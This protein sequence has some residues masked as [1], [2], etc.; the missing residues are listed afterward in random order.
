[1][2]SKR[3]DVVN[4]QRFTEVGFMQS[5]ALAYAAV[6]LVCL[7]ALGFPFWAVIVF[8][9]AAPGIAILTDHVVGLPFPHALA[10]AKVMFVNLS[11]S[12]FELFAAVVAMK[13][14]AS[15][16]KKNLLAFVTASNSWRFLERQVE[17]IWFGVKLLSANS[18]SCHLF[19]GS[20]IF[21]GAYTV[22]EPKTRLVVLD[23]TRL[24]LDFFAAMGAVDNHHF[25]I[26]I[27]PYMFYSTTIIAC[28]NLGRKCRAVE[29]SAAYCAVALQRYAD[30]TQRT[31]VLLE[32]A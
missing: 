7:S 16:T 26:C 28:E 2:Q 11:I 5:A 32:S 3:L 24:F 15:V 30:H 1:M 31:P 20:L 10:A 22:A 23:P 27:I 29:I 25:H 18:A 19:L 21:S 4:F 13:R 17:S 6:T 14:L 12:S 9:S 8:V